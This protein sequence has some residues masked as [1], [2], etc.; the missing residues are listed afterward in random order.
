MRDR[1][2]W[3][4]AAY[5]VTKSRT[6]LSDWTPAITFGVYF[7]FGDSWGQQPQSLCFLVWTA[8][9]ADPKS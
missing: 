1:E 7:H 2:A 8:R 4:A 3:S 9:L 6:R 5:R